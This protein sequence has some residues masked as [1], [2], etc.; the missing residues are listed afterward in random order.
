MKFEH[1]SETD[2]TLRTVILPLTNAGKGNY[3]IPESP[4]LR[5]RFMSLLHM[6]LTLGILIAS[7]LPAMVDN[8]AISFFAALEKHLS[9]LDHRQSFHH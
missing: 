8:G 9:M 5:M 3:Q 7:L 2:F 6:V 4:H 1:W